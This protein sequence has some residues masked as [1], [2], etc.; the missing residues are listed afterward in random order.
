MESDIIHKEKQQTNKQSNRDEENEITNNFKIA[1]EKKLILK[2][3][4][5]LENRKKNQCH[6]EHQNL[7]NTIL[8]ERKV[9]ALSFLLLLLLRAMLKYTNKN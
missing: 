2:D 9:C 6:E 4:I 5:Q 1:W 7:L 3:K 8:V